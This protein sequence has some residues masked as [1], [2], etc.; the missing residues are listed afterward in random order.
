MLEDL[1]FIAPINDDDNNVI[2]DQWAGN[3]HNTLECTD[4]RASLITEMPPAI[5]PEGRHN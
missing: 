3:S 2:L 5:M 1:V 4:A